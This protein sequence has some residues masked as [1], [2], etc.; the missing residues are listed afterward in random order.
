[1]PSMILNRL[2]TKRKY[3]IAGGAVGAV[4]GAFLL[5]KQITSDKKEEV[6]E[7]ESN[8]DKTIRSIQKYKAFSS[9]M[10][11]PDFSGDYSDIINGNYKKTKK[12]TKELKKE[13]VKSIEWDKD[14]KS[15]MR[16]MDDAFSAIST[17]PELDYQLPQLPA[18]K[19]VNPKD[20]LGDDKPIELSI[21]QRKKETSPKKTRRVKKTRKPKKVREEAESS[22]SSEP[23][24]PVS[25]PEISVERP[26]A[27]KTRK[28]RKTVSTNSSSNEEAPGRLIPI[29]KR[30]KRVRKVKA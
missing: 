18:P 1:M 22:D 7:K 13:E 29:V 17:K 16:N 19:N 9:M 27:K 12:K 2:R 28:P 4:G 6:S 11:D 14:E 21:V 24:A 5:Y 3:L 25:S 23:S 20:V 8:F 10:T 15:L 30:T 26:R